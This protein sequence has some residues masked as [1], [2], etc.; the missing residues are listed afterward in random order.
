MISQPA[1]VPQKEI[2]P[3]DVPNF[4][5]GLNLNGLQQA[6]VNSF[7][8]SK[9]VA[10]TPDGYLIPRPV[11]RPFLPDNVDTVYQIYPV[12]WNGNVY[13]ITADATA[14]GSTNGRIVYCKEGDTSWTVAGAETG[15]TNSVTVN[16]GGKPEFLRVLDTVLILNGNNGDRLAYLNLSDFKVAQY[17]SISDPAAAP[18]AAVTNIGTTG[19]FKIYYAYTYTTATGETNLSP[20]LTQNIDTVRDQ[21]ETLSPTG[22]V[23]ITRPAAPTGAQN[24]NLYVALAS[25]GG[26]IQASD[27]LQ[28]AVGLDLNTTEF[29]DNGTIAINLGSPAPVSNSTAGPHVSHGIIEEGNP[30][31][32]GDTDDPSNIWIGG[33]GANALSFSSA[34]GGYKAQPNKGTNFHVSAIIGFR[35]GQGIPSLTVL[36]S[37]TEGLAEQ[38]VLQQETVTYGNQTFSVWGVTSQH[39]GA[40][41]VAAP[42]SVINYNGKLLFMSNDGL[43]MMNTQPLRQNVISTD[44]L[45]IKTINPLIQTIINS[46]MS[47]IVGA[48]WD[49]HYMWTMPTN[50]FSTPQQ[51]LVCD[52]NNQVPENNNNGAFYTY[53][54]AAQWIGVVSSPAEAAFTYVV[55][56]NKSYKLRT[57]SATYDM[58]DGVPTPF[59]CSAAGAL[60]PMSQSGVRNTWQATVQAIFYIVGLI[61]SITIGVTYRN[62]NGKLKT[63]SKTVVGPNYRPPIVGGWGDTQWGY[64]NTPQI[65][66]WRS[67]PSINVNLPAQS[68]QD[69]RAAI[70]IDDIT[71]E[72]QWWFQTAA[73]YNNFKI[74]AFSMEGVNLG[75]RPDLQ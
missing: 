69:I 40:A 37:N 21:W 55:I 43:M 74:R 61:G 26:T 57:G 32:F 75:V 38:A 49:N 17:T 2:T 59:S 54:I 6:Q 41:G 72:A 20:I 68:P 13:Y 46:A 7:T 58:T 39:Y 19:T 31:L 65:P 8:S 50:G 34:L 60:V 1:K 3:V 27:M 18:T 5:S 64:A 42:D 62:Q 70:Q 45:S 63:K 24:W 9:D 71:N 30:I 4:A 33:G 51:I 25:T 23:T 47:T 15:S 36:F 10:L 52:D 73:G 28:L 53:N 16:N 66:G 14:K 44:N 56:G 29:V 48:A 11:L 35:N 22:K 67:S 12:Y